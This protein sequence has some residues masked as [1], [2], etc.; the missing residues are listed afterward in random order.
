MVEFV[1]Y[2]TGSDRDVTF[3]Q[4]Q[5]DL[6]GACNSWQITQR[7]RKASEMLVLGGV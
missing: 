1:L 7:G 2:H 4:Q 6:K 5:G 3:D